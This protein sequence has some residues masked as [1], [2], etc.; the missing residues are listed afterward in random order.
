MEGKYSFIPLMAPDDGGGG[1][2]NS[3]ATGGDVGADAGGADGQGTGGEGI[4]DGGAQKTV[5]TDEASAAVQARI[6]QLQDKYER[7]TAPLRQLAE[8]ISRRSG[9]TVDQVLERLD[10]EERQQA[11]Q[12][13]GLT[14][15]M[16]Q[17]LQ[18]LTGVSTQTAAEVRRLQRDLERNT[19]KA[20]P[21]YADYDSVRESVEAYADKY[22][23][24]LREAYWAVNGDKRTQQL[25]RE[26][27]QRAI[28]Q[29]ESLG[30]LGAV[31]GDTPI[32]TGP[33]KFPNA[34]AA[35]VAKQMG[36]DAEEFNMLSGEKK[37]LDDYDRLIEKR[38]KKR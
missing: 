37:N 1:G 17:Y 33:D 19:L 38:S 29:R 20:D 13:T 3:A 5:T 11:A 31:S 36:L 2:G 8:K 27:E 14:P 32:G 15:A 34:D 21:T 12:Q 35:Y 9:L 6:R 7:E 28:A 26:A 22:G 10:A 24:S 18:N 25:A 23:V 16:V 30:Y 4:T